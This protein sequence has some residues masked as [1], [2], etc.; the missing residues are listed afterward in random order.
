MFM[1]KEYDY[2][3]GDIVELHFFR[4]KKNAEKCFKNILTEFFEAVPDH[5]ES[6]LEDND[7]ELSKND[8]LNQYFEGGYYE[9]VV[10]FEEI[11]CED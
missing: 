8:I 7:F 2:A 5:L 9:G 1:V 11:E 3:Y 4:E 6:I 10:T